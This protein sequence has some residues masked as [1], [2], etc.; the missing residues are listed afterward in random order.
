MTRPITWA[1]NRIV[2]AAALAYA[3]QGR[4]G[5]KCQSIGQL[6]A[7][8]AGLLLCSYAANAAEQGPDPVVLDNEHLR[9]EIDPGNGAITRILDKQ[10]Q[11]QLVPADGMAENFRLVLRGLDAKQWTILG[12]SQK[13]SSVS[14][15]GGG[16][17]LAWKGP[18]ADTTGGTHNL[19]TRMEIRLAGESLEFRVFVENESEHKVTEVSYPLI[20]GLAGFGTGEARDETFLMLP[21]SSPSIKKIALPFGE[22]R[23]VYPGSMCM[24]FSSVFNK[25]NGRAMYF[26]SHDSVAR[27]KHY[28][29][30]EQSSP[31]GKDVFAS[32]QHVP[33]TPAGEGFEGSPVV[34]RFHDGS[35]HAAGPI[36]RDWF[37]KTF[38]LM[39]PSRS[40]I[41]RHS[42]V[43]DTMFILPEGTLNYTFEDI[44]RWAKDARDHGVTAV[45]VSGWHRG[46]H[47]NGYPHYEPDPRL[48]T[49]EDL[50]RGLDACHKMGVQVYFFINYQPVMVE[51]EWYKK[52]LIRY[53]E[54]REDGGPTVT[55]GWGMGTLWARMGHPKTV[56]WV[57]PSFPEYRD[58]LLAQ[59]RKLVEAGA[60]GVH[61]D[62]MFPSWMNF[63]PRCELGPDT[64][65]WEGAVR[66]TQMLLDQSRKINPD[67]AMSFEC[68]WDRMLQFGNAIWWVGNM[69][70][71][72]SVFPEMVETR[73]IASPYDYLGINDLVRSSEVGLLVPLNC[74]R[75]VGWEPWKGLA[76][77]I[78]E[79]KRIQD[80]LSDTVFLGEVLGHEQIQLEH[81]PKYG[82]KHNVFRCLKTGKHACILTNSDM[83]DSVQGITGFEG[84]SGGSVRIHS[85]FAAPRDAALPVKVTVPGEGIVFVEE[86]AATA[87]R[88]GL[89]QPPVEIDLPAAPATGGV[90]NGGFE[91]GD[92]TGW[93]AD[94]NW[95]VDRNTCG[96]YGGWSGKCFAWSGGQGE[97]AT[98]CLKSKPF[99]LDK[100]AVRL[101]MA[102][103]NAAPGSN[104]TWNHVSLKLADGS[105]EID[106][107][108]APNSLAFVPV[109]LDG[110][111]F[112]G[113]LVYLE[114][115]DDADQGGFSM[116]CIDDVRTVPLPY[117]R[118]RPL[119]PVP[120]FDDQ[121]SIKL[122]N[123]RYR[124]EVSRANGTVTRILDTAAN[125]ELIRE[126]RLAGNFKFTLPLPGEEPWE[127]IE[128]NYILGKDQ[129][130]SSF[131]L[132]GGTLTLVWRKP[133]KNR[134]GEEYDVTATMGIELESEAVRFTLRIENN[135]PYQVGEVFFPVLGGVT[136]LGNTHRELKATQLVR[137]SGAGAVTTSKIFFVFGNRSGLGDQGA[138]QFYTYPVE[139]PEPWMEFQNPG[140]RRSIY[141]GSHDPADRSKVLHLEMLPG[142]AAT[143]RWDG[144]WPRFEELNGLPAGVIVAFVDFANHPPGKTYEAAPVVLQAH[145][146]DWREGQRIYQTWKDSR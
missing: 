69:S 24:S 8:A 33:F 131:D 58:A 25:K 115:L 80:H 27:L 93:T 121:E 77:Y 29:F 15:V 51:S 92:F 3:G 94:P 91:S 133:L 134:A 22:I 110:S 129:P 124:V 61:V 117:N 50:K 84:N 112:Q 38:G 111:E 26:A 63:N 138:E 125:L 113:K 64:S 136:G 78:R 74:C 135:T 123:D 9:I 7:M 60:D 108:S 105:T 18:L 141:L 114:A 21:T 1:V 75:S 143:P 52:E 36:Y 99:L 106:R 17:D 16:L 34:L 62:K 120:E 79:V 45:L 59:F 140:R 95:R 32:I 104:R 146:G 43:Q 71:V 90:L 67:F 6:T 68:N 116:F 122:E 128:A 142:N 139:L 97:A 11:I 100:D 70:L 137:P 72:R 12:R 40:W 44:P 76:N 109:V 48:G 42:F 126:P 55:S 98:G 19:Q 47:D 81:E 2:S 31:A 37:T 102:G 107:A 144:N 20:G 28:R 57:D 83:D 65:T 53:L 127:T 101:L 41:R 10:G 119:D 132:D 118:T 23:H 73:L 5:L 56:T 145:G 46:G 88:D 82:V 30:F 49:Y 85:P 86:L 39:D 4:T 87:S 13:L 54:M 89:P 35:W 103:W 14:K 130:L 96:E 66:I